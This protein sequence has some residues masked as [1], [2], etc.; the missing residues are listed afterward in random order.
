M[1][2]VA[3]QPEP[4]VGLWVSY[5]LAK[6]QS[7]RGRCRAGLRPA[8][9][10]RPFGGRGHAGLVNESAAKVALDALTLVTEARFG[11]VQEMFAPSLR[12]LVTAQA[13]QIGWLAAVDQAGAVSAIGDPP[14]RTR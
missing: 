10:C 6:G 11:E 8:G 1:A 14:R 13:I 3:R 7:R 5:Q 4:V 2:G 12:A 9:A